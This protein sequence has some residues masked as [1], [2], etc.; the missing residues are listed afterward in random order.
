MIRCIINNRE[1]ETSLP[2]GSVALDFI[3]QQQKLFGTKEGCREGECGTCT[4]LIGELKDHD[5]QYKTTASCLL[6][7]GELDKKH[8]VT[9]EGLNTDALSLT[10]VQQALVEE[11]A[12]QCGFCTPGIVMSLTGF[13][14]SSQTLD[15]QDAV[16]AL[17]GNICRCTGYASIQRAAR[18]LCDTFAPQLEKSNGKN[19]IK[20][21]VKSSVLP[22]YFLQIPRRL[23]AP[24]P[25]EPPH[26]TPSKHPPAEGS[27]KI[28][29]AG[30]TD[31]YV[32]QPEDLVD[33]NLEFVSRRS[34]LT[35]MQRKNNWL[36][37]GAGTT[38]E[39]MK[40]S[41]L[42]NELFPNMKDYL[43]LVSSTIM[44]NRA[45]LAGNIV[46][47]SPIGDLT[48]ILLALEA[49]LCLVKGKTRRELQLKEF[50]KG[51]KKLDMK[52]GEIIE[53]IEIPIPYP[54]CDSR[55]HFEKVSRRKYLDIAS[56]NSAISLE[57]DGNMINDIHL[58]AGGVAPIP[59][60]LEETCSWLRG[61]EVT[62]ANICE[63]VKIVEQE[64]SP[65][66]DVRGSAHYKS[67]LL[68]NLIFAHF[69]TL[70]PKKE[71]EEEL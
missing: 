45:T 50:F 48:I 67:L 31:L 53:T 14:L 30:G 39:E 37:I 10:L 60:Y 3:R 40:H 65:I 21:L 41:P 51:Y 8:I 4:I 32:Q 17:D 62:A 24:G 35:G 13:L 7:L 38:V 36:F 58:S 11:G 33:K 61:K 70:F 20:Q 34:D 6:P 9:V 52:K 49:D 44:R 15:Y 59:L 25:G 55:F 64:I 22:D 42:I 27:K 26:P 1:V 29:V 28:I 47:A 12:S 18:K 63:A 56:C 46:N 2:T 23:N 68:R 57:L 69:I 66:S 54:G 19:R 16:D 5:L 43:N 71:L